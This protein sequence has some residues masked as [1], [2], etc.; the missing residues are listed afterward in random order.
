MRACPVPPYGAPSRPSREDRTARDREGGVWER[1]GRRALQPGPAERLAQR[2]DGSSN[3]RSDDGS[4][5]DG[6]GEGS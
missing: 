5:A 4:S 2:S 6:L 1:T 3:G